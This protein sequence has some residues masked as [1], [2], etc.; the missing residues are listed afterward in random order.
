VRDGN[1][2]D[3]TA[4]R[5]EASI[6]PRWRVASTR[7][8]GCGL[9]LHIGRPPGGR[10]ERSGEVIGDPVDLSITQFDQGDELPRLAVRICDL[11]DDGE[12]ISCA[13]DGRRL[14]G[15]TG[16]ACLFRCSARIVLDDRAPV[17]LAADALAG[18]RVLLDKVIGEQ[19][20]L[21]F[22]AVGILGFFEFSACGALCRC[23]WSSS[24]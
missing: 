4:P 17:V 8:R 21:A 16:R 2:Y 5:T 14:C 12:L 23:T 22:A 18:L 24:P 1:R 19:P 6:L 9:F 10:L 3:P 13:R 15:G 20:V 7:S 11:T